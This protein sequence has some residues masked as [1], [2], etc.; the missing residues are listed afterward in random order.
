MRF[1]RSKL[2]DELLAREEGTG[3]E[4]EGRHEMGR[5]RRMREDMDRAMSSEILHG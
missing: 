1:V 2:C 4:Q 3:R 5:Y